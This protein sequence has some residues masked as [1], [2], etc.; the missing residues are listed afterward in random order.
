[1]RVIRPFILF[2]QSFRL[3]RKLRVMM[4]D[5]ECRF[6]GRLLLSTL[7]TLVIGLRPSLWIA[8]AAM[9]PD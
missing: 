9:R 8:A 2:S 6:V 5:E 7:R 4:D 3:S 1:M